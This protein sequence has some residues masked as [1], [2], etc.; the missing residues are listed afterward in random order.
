MEENAEELLEFSAKER[1]ILEETEREGAKPISAQLAA[2]LFTVFL[3]GYSCAEIADLNKD[4]LLSEGDILYCRKKFNWDKQKYDYTLNLQKQIGEKLL[5]IKLESIQF[6]TNLLSVTHKI[7]NERNL[8][9]LQTGNPEE[10]SEE[11]A[12]SP[13]SYKQVWEII[14]K[15]T[16]EDKI[17][18]HEI[19]SESIR[20]E[21]E[22][23]KS[24]NADDQSILLKKLVESKD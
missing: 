2:Q 8:K 7:N 15:I 14:Q 10:L 3:E 16:G 4:K 5:K 17:T 13:T 22:A 1:K 24:I 23:N 20:I 11:W 19:K 18:K 12:K 9:Y 21:N 6:L